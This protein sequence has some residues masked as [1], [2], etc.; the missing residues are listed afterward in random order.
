MHDE[1]EPSPALAKAREHRIEARLGGDVGLDDDIAVEAFRERP[2][3]LAQCVALVGEGEPGA[4]VVQ[5]LGDAPG[6]RAVIGDA[7]DEPLLPGHHA[8]FLSL[9]R[10]R[11]ARDR[12]GPHLGRIILHEASRVG[13]AAGRGPLGQLAPG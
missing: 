11:G 13:E 12:A 5:C 4:V 3:A 10:R 6:E 9:R 2:H 8:H 1:I 7:H